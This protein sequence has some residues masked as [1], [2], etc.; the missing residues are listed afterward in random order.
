MEILTL[1]SKGFEKLVNLETL[2][3]SYTKLEALPAG[4]MHFKPNV[5]IITSNLMSK[6]RI[7]TP[8][9]PK[10]LVS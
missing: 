3:L 1:L 9:S 2:D 8:R 6:N 4:F 10:D 7:L 5:Q